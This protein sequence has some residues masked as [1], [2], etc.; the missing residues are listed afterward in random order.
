[1]KLVDWQIESLQKR[2]HV[3][4]PFEGALVRELATGPAMAYGLARDGYVLR[5]SSTSAVANYRMTVDPKYLPKPNDTHGLNFIPAQSCMMALT[6]E[7]VTLPRGYTGRLELTQEY[8]LTGL[9]LVAPELMG[10]TDGC[11]VLVTLINPMAVPIVLY[12]GEGIAKL[13]IADEA[14]LE[15]RSEERRGGVGLALPE[16]GGDGAGA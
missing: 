5:L 12:H 8:A 2:R 6:V 15:P 11:R 10:G 4:E 14:P 3:I 1:M 9:Q 13:V 16:G 7:T